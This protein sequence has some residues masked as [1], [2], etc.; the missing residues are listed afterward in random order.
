MRWMPQTGDRLA[1]SLERL[2]RSCLVGPGP[3][4]LQHKYYTS[5]HR[6]LLSYPPSPTYTI[7]TPSLSTLLRKSLSLALYLSYRH[8]I[9]FI[10]NYVRALQVISAYIYNDDVNYYNNPR[11]LNAYILSKPLHR[12]PITDLDVRSPRP[13]NYSTALSEWCLLLPW[14]SSSTSTSF[15]TLLILF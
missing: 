2:R 15:L 6:M 9:R 10:A 3:A 12:T 11:W 14:C 1:P 8:L 7:K 5:A 4:L 13:S